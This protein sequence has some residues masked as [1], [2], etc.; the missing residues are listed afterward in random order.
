LIA[1]FK[2]LRSRIGSINATLSRK[3]WKFEVAEY[4]ILLM[5]VIYTVI[6]SYF[7]IMVHYSFRTFAWDLGI[8]TQSMASATKG[9]LFVNNVELYYTPT[10]SYFGIHFAPILFTIIPIFSLLPTAETL[11]VIQSTL[12]KISSN[13]SHGKHL[14]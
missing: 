9:Q 10:G 4:M 13:R 7:T 11:L 5:V 1:T 6:F 8:F 2:S 3:L 12:T 14:R